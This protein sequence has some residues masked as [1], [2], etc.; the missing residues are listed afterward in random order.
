MI[1]E[2]VRRVSSSLGKDAIRV[3]A[4]TGAAAINIEGS[5]IH[6]LLHFPMVSSKFQPLNGEAKTNFQNEMKELKFIIIDE[7]SMIGA[8]ILFMIERRLRE[9]QPGVDE[10]F[11]GVFVYF[12]GDFRQLPPVKDAPLYSNSFFDTMSQQGRLFFNEFQFFIE[13]GCSHRQSNADESFRNMLENLASGTFTE[14]DH[15]LLASRSQSLLSTDELEIFKTAVELYPTNEQVRANNES[16]LESL[17]LPVANIASENTPD[18]VPTANDDAQVG[19]PAKLKLS[20]GSRV[21]LRTNLWVGGG[22]VNGTL[23]TVRYIVYSP[24]ARPPSL[25]LF[26]LVEFDQYRGPSVVDNLFPFI[27]MTRSW[28][29]KGITR[30]R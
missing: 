7:M 14:A 4:P 11:G 16:H 22:L 23:G 26:I 25:P 5:T 2:I 1:K 21:M 27:P 30:I 17:G 8:Q 15:T 6:S 28:N 10:P 13:L 24:D 29:D 18:I 9:T 20:I 3:C 12:F 19:L